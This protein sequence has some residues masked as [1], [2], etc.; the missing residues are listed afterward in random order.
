MALALGVLGATVPA[1][2]V[3]PQTGGQAP[4]TTAFITTG[5]EWNDNY[6]LTSDSVGTALIWTTTIG[7]GLVTS[8]PVDSFDLAVRGSLRVSDLPEIGVD[9][10]L[11]DPTLDLAY[12][13]RVDDD[14]IE[15][16]AQYRRVDV[17]FFDPLRDINPDG[18]FDDTRGTGTRETIRAGFGMVLNE[19]GP[20]AFDFGISAFQRNYY[21]TTDT[22]LFDQD[23]FFGRAE[24][25]ARVSPLLSLTVGGRYEE[26][27]SD[28]TSQTEKNRARVDVGFDARVNARLTARVRLGYSEVET[29]RNGNTTRSNGRVGGI[30]F[31]TAARNGTLTYG[32]RSELTE[33]GTRNTVDIARS[34][35]RD[36]GDLN[37]SLGLSN[38]DSTPVRPV[39]RLAYTYRNPLTLVDLFFQQSARVDEDGNDTLNTTLG[40]GYTRT[41]TRVSSLSL[42]LLA[43]LERF[44]E[45]ERVNNERV[46]FSA[47]YNQQLPQ[48]WVASIGYRLQV[49][50]SETD[51]RSDSNA[52]FIDLTRRFEAL[53]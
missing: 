50:D 36:D 21:D 39:G 48:E 8:T 29:K 27:N 12:S 11:D 3:W 24:V 31:I 9:A 7:A 34:L 19:D 41:L 43:G 42:D 52:V 45:E 26:Q 16:T 5:L 38:S 37:L 22:G 49:R 32:A 33:N 46:T 35:Q 51:D 23:D 20:L 15:L 18:S 44:E 28:N 14:G 6:N 2:A 40:L 10:L 4:R 25:R 13:R 53:R 47:R 17:D 30:D 1:T